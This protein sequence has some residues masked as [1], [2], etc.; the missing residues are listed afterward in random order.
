[1]SDNNEQEI[2]QNQTYGWIEFGCWTAL[3]ITPVLYWVNGPAV[4]QDQLVVRS[5]VVL[6]A[7]LGGV[8]LRIHAWRRRGG[9]AVGR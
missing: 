4:S 3:A 9:T 7:L 6:V 2:D 5:L 1:M 8:G